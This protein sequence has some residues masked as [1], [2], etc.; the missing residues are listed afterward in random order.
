MES[1]LPWAQ[2]AQ[3]KMNCATKCQGPWRPK[4]CMFRSK[5]KK[6]KKAKTASNFVPVPLG[7]DAGKTH[8]TALPAGAGDR[9]S[10]SPY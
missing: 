1:R 4:S 8:M 6:K 7:P 9:Y 10:C 5:F 2:D 3:D